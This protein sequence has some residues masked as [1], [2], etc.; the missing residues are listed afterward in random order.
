MSD[1]F[2]A[3]DAHPMLVPVLVIVLSA[4]TLVDG[5]VHYIDGSSDPL[6]PWWVTLLL[7]VGGPMTVVGLSVVQIVRQRALLGI[8]IRSASVEPPS[9]IVRV[10]GGMLR[11]AAR[12]GG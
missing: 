1:L 10:V 2:R 12:V 4:W 3:P 9:Q 5:L 6:F 7:V 8:D 11:R